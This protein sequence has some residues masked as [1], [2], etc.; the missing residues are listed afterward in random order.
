VFVQSNRAGAE[1]RMEIAAFLKQLNTDLFVLV[2]A[3]QIL[4][5]EV[6]LLEVSKRFLVDARPC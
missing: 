3:V 5:I 2:I 4:Q 6:A 1:I